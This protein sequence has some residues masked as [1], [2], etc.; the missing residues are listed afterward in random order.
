MCFPGGIFLK[1]MG[2]NCLL[3]KRSWSMVVLVAGTGSRYHAKCVKETKNQKGR[4][5][6][7]SKEGKE[8]R[9]DG[10][11]L[12]GAV[13]STRKKKKAFPFEDSKAWRIHWTDVCPYM[14]AWFFW[15]GYTDHT[16]II[17]RWVPWTTKYLDLATRSSLSYNYLFSFEMDLPLYRHHPT[18]M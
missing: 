6:K 5:P 11:S 16:W 3:R 12:Q 8:G 1:F 7:E 9:R 4:K 15:Y 2:K 10:I 13:D 18:P 14:K 17:L